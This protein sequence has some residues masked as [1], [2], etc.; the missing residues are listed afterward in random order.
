[1]PER[2]SRSGKM[3][4]R[5]HPAARTY[6]SRTVPCGSLNVNRP[7]AALTRLNHNRIVIVVANVYC[8]GTIF[9]CRKR[10]FFEFL[11]PAEMPHRALNV[12]GGAMQ[13][14][15]QQDRFVV[16]RR[17]AGHRADC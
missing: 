5:E 14:D 4:P 16:R 17:H 10:G 13:R 8:A 7:S 2:A 12:R 11:D 6:S 15:V 9:F 3:F 1:M